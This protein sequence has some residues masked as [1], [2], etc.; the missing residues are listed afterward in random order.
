MNQRRDSYGSGPDRRLT[1]VVA[2]VV[3]AVLA[4][5]FYVFV[6]RDHNKSN[7]SPSAVNTSI[8]GTFNYTNVPFTFSYPGNFALVNPPPTGFLWIGGIGPYDIIDV[9]RLSNSERSLDATR[10]AVKQSLQVQPNVKITGSGTDR[11]GSSSFEVVRFNVDS[12]VAG[13][14]LHSKLYYFSHGGASWQLECQATAAGTAQ[15]TSACNLALS[16]FQT[17]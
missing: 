11:I 9:K 17:K 7:G 14:T 12:S 10:N 1:I 4:G 5:L 2:V 6:I 16:S 13:Q 15:M 3:V 8:P